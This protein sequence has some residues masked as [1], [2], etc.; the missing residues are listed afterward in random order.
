MGNRDFVRHYWCQQLCDWANVYV[1][2]NGGMREFGAI[3]IKFRLFGK[4]KLDLMRWMDFLLDIM[5]IVAIIPL[6]TFK[7]VKKHDLN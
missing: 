6:F 3:W 2:D 5:L 1:G 4:F 7:K